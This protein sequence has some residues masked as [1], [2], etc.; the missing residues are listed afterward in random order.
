MVE[1]NILKLCSVT[2]NILHIDKS[3]KKCG[4]ALILE[5]MDH[6]KVTKATFL[7]GSKIYFKEDFERELNKE[8]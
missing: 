7:N 3:R 1:E 5:L 6:F 2:S 8:R 4:P